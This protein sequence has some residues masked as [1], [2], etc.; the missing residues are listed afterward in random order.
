MMINNI[1][2]IEKAYSLSSTSSPHLSSGIIVMFVT[3]NKNV[4]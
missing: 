4:H 1:M 3:N 2:W